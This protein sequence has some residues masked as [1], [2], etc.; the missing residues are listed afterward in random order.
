M[1]TDWKAYKIESCFVAGIVLIA[2]V[3]LLLLQRQSGPNMVKKVSVQRAVENNSVSAKASGAGTNIL[4]KKGMIS[5]TQHPT[6]DIKA[7]ENDAQ[8]DQYSAAY[9]ITLAQRKC[10]PRFAYQVQVSSRTTTK[11]TALATPARNDTLYE[12]RVWMVYSVD[13]GLRLDTSR[14]K[15][16]FTVDIATMLEKTVPNIPWT[17]EGQDT[18]E[19][20]PTVRLCSRSQRGSITLWISR[21]DGAVLRYAQSLDGNDLASC[22]VIYTPLNGSLVPLQTVIAFPLT[23]RTVTQDYTDYVVQGDSK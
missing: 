5:S 4:Y 3:V 10:V 16:S 19:G 11:G 21:D 23:A 15:G 18:L 12:G 9:W 14:G 13:N 1:K 7:A 20:K 17:I 8:I 6:D 2:I 22:D